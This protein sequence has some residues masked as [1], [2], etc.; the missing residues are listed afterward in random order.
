[1]YVTTLR[2]LRYSTACNLHTSLHHPSYFLHPR[3]SKWSKYNAN[4]R[5]AKATKAIAAY[6]GHMKTLLENVPVDEDAP[7]LGMLAKMKSLK[8][9][10]SNEFMAANKRIGYTASPGKGGGMQNPAHLQTVVA[11]AAALVGQQRR[12]NGPTKILNL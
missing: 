3:T 5:P 10:R 1:M 8:R 11:I 4:M 2:R 9:K 7:A 6:K 12:V